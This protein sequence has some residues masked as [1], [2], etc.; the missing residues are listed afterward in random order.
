L[1]YTTGSIDDGDTA[2]DTITSYATSAGRHNATGCR[3][4]TIS[5]A[6]ANANAANTKSDISDAESECSGAAWTFKRTTNTRSQSDCRYG[7]AAAS[8]CGSRAKFANTTSGIINIVK[9]YILH[10]NFI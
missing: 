6:A 8:S 7:I 5:N 2:T 4:D 10:N 3:A 1:R 9:E